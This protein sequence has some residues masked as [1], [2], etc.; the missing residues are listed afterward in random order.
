M[1]VLILLFD[2]NKGDSQQSLIIKIW[3]ALCWCIG[4]QNAV[5][6]RGN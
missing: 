4:L 6:S 2:A 3:G 1:K 5:D